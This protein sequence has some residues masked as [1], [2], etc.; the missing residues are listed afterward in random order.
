MKISA[1][2]KD[3]ERIAYYLHRL[4]AR[5]PLRKEQECRAAKR[6]GNLIA[7]VVSEQRNKWMDD[8]RK[9]KKEELEEFIFKQGK[10]PD[11]IAEIMGTSPEKV[12]KVLRRMN[13]LRMK[14]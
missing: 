1:R 9:W 14:R 4:A 6:L 13:L 2:P 11:E 7:V 10:T 12:E 3:W 8:R 5:E